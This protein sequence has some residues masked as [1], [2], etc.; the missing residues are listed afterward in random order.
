MTHQRQP[1]RGSSGTEPSVLPLESKSSP[2]RAKR[3]CSR[4]SGRST[5]ESKAKEV[6]MLERARQRTAIR[7][8][9]ATRD[10]AAALTA[11]LV[12]LFSDAAF[13]SL[14]HAQGC[15]SIPKLIHQSLTE[16]R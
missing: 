14:L 12:K 13:V 9:Q 6:L 4:P 8:M 11:V 16:R 15:S 1:N 7:R 10:E 3:E 2:A 5:P